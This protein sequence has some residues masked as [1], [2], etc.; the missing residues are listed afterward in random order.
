[1]FRTSATQLILKPIQGGHVKGQRPTSGCTHRTVQSEICVRRKGA[2]I[3]G[4]VHSKSRRT[5]TLCHP[6]WQNVVPHSTMSLNLAPLPGAIPTVCALSGMHSVHIHRVLLSSCS[7]C[8]FLQRM[9]LAL[10][11]ASINTARHT[12]H[13]DGWGIPWVDAI[14]RPPAMLHGLC[15]CTLPSTSPAIW[16][17][18]LLMGMIRSTEYLGSRLEYVPV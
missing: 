16:G 9:Q 3:L 13:W 15:P 2:A 11:H 8:E 10:L 14:I 5:Q 17:K 6:S 12:H 7:R 4:S 1:M 18:A